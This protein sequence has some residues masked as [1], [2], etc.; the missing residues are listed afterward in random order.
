MYASA[1]EVRFD[2]LSL[3]TPT[4]LS[5]QN[6]YSTGRFDNKSKATNSAIENKYTKLQEKMHRDYCSFP[7]L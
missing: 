1:R 3:L 6:V 4:I 2:L 7:T 5:V